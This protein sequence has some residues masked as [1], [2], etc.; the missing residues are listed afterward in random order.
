MES[1]GDGMNEH[2]ADKNEAVNKAADN[3]AQALDVAIE[4]LEDVQKMV[5]SGRPKSLNIKF[6]DKTVAK[7][8]L[9]LTAAAAFAAG[10][11]AVLLTKL[12]IEIEHED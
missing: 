11:A 1:S 3:T 5:G 12:A 10:L 2:I 6:G 9:A 4:V 8:P 7:M